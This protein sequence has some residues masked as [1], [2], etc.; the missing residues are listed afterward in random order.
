MSTTSLTSEHRAGSFWRRLTEVERAA[1]ARQARFRRFPKGSK[2]ISAR[3]RCRWAAIVYSGRVRVVGANAVTTRWAGDIVGEQSVVDRSARPDDVVADTEVKALVLGEEE[4]DG[5]FARFPHVVLTLCAVAS[6]RLREADRAL[7]SQAGD[8]LTRVVDLL[9]RL[10]GESGV[11]DR[12]KVLIPIGSQSAL[13]RQLRLSRESVVRA[14]R[15]L[16]DQRLISTD[17]RGVVVVHDL[18]AL[19]AA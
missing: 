15:T 9:L 8:A 13:G 5:L 7:E 19:R 16:R 4:L 14:F 11:D 18:D 6:E 17:R 3:D 1:F 10:A 12:H 2:L